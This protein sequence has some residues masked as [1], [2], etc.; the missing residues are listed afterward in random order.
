MLASRARHASSFIDRL[1]GLLNTPSLN[2]GEGLY[3]APCSQ[4]HMFG[5]KY[6]IDVVFLDKQGVVVGVCNSIQ[7][8]Q[9]SKLFVHAYGCV[10]LPTGI[11]RD[12]STCEG[13][14]IE[15]GPSEPA[16]VMD[17]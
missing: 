7:P 2:S 6:A 8:G 13:D 12:T 15:S 9:V 17:S 11:V 14:L 5:M 10:E 3:I 1:V 4:I 16:K